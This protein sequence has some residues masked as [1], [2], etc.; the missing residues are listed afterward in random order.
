MLSGIDLPDE[1][2]EK[3][4]MSFLELSSKLNML[5]IN[6]DDYIEY[7]SA[8]TIFVRNRILKFMTEFD[9]EDGNYLGLGLVDIWVNYIKE[10]STR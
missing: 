9:V 5:R 7:Y 2:T 4:N 8:K 6:T 1:Y 10:V 3:K